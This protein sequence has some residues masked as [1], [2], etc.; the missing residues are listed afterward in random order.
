MIGD[1][2]SAMGNAAKGGFRRE[3]AIS[4]STGFA[5]AACDSAAALMNAIDTAGAASVELDYRLAGGVLSALI[6]MLKASHISVSSVHNFCPVPPVL[7]G[8]RGGGDLFPLTDPDPEI[9][10]EAV[11]WTTRSIETAHEAEAGIV[12]LHGGAVILDHEEDRWHALFRQGALESESSRAFIE[13]KL[14][15]LEARKPPFLDRLR[16]SLDRLFREAERLGVTLAL[17]NRYHYYE[18]PGPTDFS[19][20]FAEFAGAP[21]GYWH[22]TGHAHAAQMLAIPSASGMLEALAPRMVGV[23][24]H[25]AKGLEDHL[26]PGAGE[27]D[28]NG[29]MEQVSHDARLVLEL[30]PGIDAAVVAEAVQWA[31]E[32]KAR[33]GEVPSDH[34][35]R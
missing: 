35:G 7:P 19:G 32:L 26:P 27:I 9:R 28:F 22:D 11:R 34:E 2:L 6:P 13:G 4:V 16:F 17:E 8:S 18:L 10:R 31:A 24:L 3:T 12:V 21:L 1:A 14:A 20:L 15:A 33:G 5:A 23:H 29:L 30:R 25:D